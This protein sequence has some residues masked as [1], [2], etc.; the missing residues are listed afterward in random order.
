MSN[1]TKD[2]QEL[3]DMLKNKKITSDELIKESI[4]KCHDIQKEINAFVTIIDDAKSTK[5]TKSLLSGIPYG[6]KDNFSTEGVLSTGSSNTLKDYIP[7]FDAT[8]IKKL[9]DSGAVGVA[10][11][12]LDELGMG[13]TGTTGHTGKVLNPWDHKRSTSG[14]SAGSAASVASG[15][16]PFA[17]GSDT[18]DSIRKPAA[19]N[20]VVG[21]KPTYGMVSRYGLFAF[22]SSLDTVGCLTRNVK[23]AAIVIDNIKGID[24][25]DMTTFDSEN[26]KLFDSID[27]NVKGKKLFYIKE[28]CDLSN[29]SNPSDELKEH[30]DNYKKTIEHAKELGMN[31]E[32][33][34]IDRT[35]LNALPAAY[36]VISCA[37][38]TS[39]MSNLTGIPFGPRGEGDDVMEMMKDHRTKGFSPLIKRRFVIGSYVLQSEN[40][41]KYFLNAKRVRRLIVNK[42]NEMFEKYDALILPVASGPAKYITD[43]NNIY[44]GEV[45]LL[46][47]HL[48]IGNY[49][50]FPSITIPNGFV[51]KLP[52]GVNITGKVKDDINVLN[53]AYALESSM[54]YKN[55]IAKEVK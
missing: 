38:A 22:A 7:F 45:N 11:T 41:E 9:K 46:E 28:I 20:G 36:I 30:L 50:G 13:G 23:D 5:D 31:V 43:V 44:T 4:S 33:V 42:M 47:E 2:I 1:M 6:I 55:Q 29:Y 12:V 21:Y 25:N 8:V 16:Y 27:G 24:K 3:H 49:G 48:Q 15:A 19:Y 51:S 35:L 34:S 14:S 53:I 40:Q 10:K 18:G 32:E 52:V 26:I 39:N 37:E 54:E 17:L